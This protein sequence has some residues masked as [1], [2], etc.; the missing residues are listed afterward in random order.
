MKPPLL[1]D[2][3]LRRLALATLTLACAAPVI[4]R[5]SRMEGLS[6]ENYPIFERL[7][8]LN[9]HV[10]SL[11]MLAALALTLVWAAPRNAAEWLA[12]WMGAHPLRA[13]TLV[14]A[15]LLLGARFIYRAHPLS[16]DE[17]VPWMQAHAFAKGQ[18]VLHYPL[19]LLDAVVPLQFQGA[20]V[21][22]DHASGAATSGYWPGL[23]LLLTPLVAPDLGWCLNPAFGALTLGLLHR[24]ASDAAG[25]ERAGGWAMLAA[26]A[27]PQFTVSAMSWYAMP[28]ELALNLLYLW[29]LLKP[30]PGAAFAAGLV[31]GLCLVMH[32]PVPHALMA[33]P[34]LLWLALDRTRWAR[35]LAVLAGYVPLGLGLGLGWWLLKAG[36]GDAPIDQPAPAA[37]VLDVLGRVLVWP[38]ASLLTARWQA[39]W[40]TWIW[41]APGLLLL[42]LLS[43]QRPPAERLLLAA[44]V[45]TFVF[46]LFVR[47]DQGHGWG[48]RYVHPVWGALPVVAGLWLA[49]AQGGARRWGSALLAAGLLATPVFLWQTQATIDHALSFRLTPEGPGD[50]VVFVSQTTGR[51]RGDL[52]QNPASPAPRLNLVSRGERADRALMANFYPGAI[53]VMQDSRGSA[54]RLPAGRLSGATP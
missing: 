22:V 15:A 44:L 13:S 12:A 26:L 28:G 9:D 49:G 40:K 23:A 1:S 29:L 11:A 48:F 20:F 8:T 21:I 25:D 30:R 16:M 33:A 45:L 39:A 4:T 42:P 31:G 51:Y 7:F 32:N 36:F 54:W 50:W 27:S 47:F 41:A 43:R 35:L 53:E 10:Q 6:L 46:Y 17:Y 14:F 37:G 3:A 52:V 18:G 19:A 5:L 24:L 34:C 2:P 38:D